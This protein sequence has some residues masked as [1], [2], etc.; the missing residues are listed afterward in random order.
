MRNARYVRR[1][2]Y[3]CMLCFYVMYECVFVVCINIL[4]TL[5]M[6]VMRVRYV[7]CVRMSVFVVHYL[8]Y[9]CMY[10]CTLCT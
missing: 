7:V 8:V 4:C 6:Y 3:A 10:V 1:A 5:S 9:A 2:R